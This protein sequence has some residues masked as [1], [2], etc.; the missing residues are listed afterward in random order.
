MLTLDNLNLA[1]GFRK[2]FAIR[3]AI[4]EAARDDVF[5]IRH[6]VYCNDL[7][8]EPTREDGRETDTH[9]GNSLHCLL[10]TSTVPARPVGCTRVVLAIQDEPDY[11]LPFE[12][13]CAKTLDRSII[14]PSRLARNRI[15]E[16]SRLAVRASYRRRRGEHA[17]HF[18]FG[19]DDYGTSEQ[20]RFP[21][22]P[23]SLYL[24][25]I[26]LAARNDIEILF[27]LTEPRLLTHF[28]RLGA[29]MRQIG[30]PVSHRGVRVPSMMDVQGVIKD[31]PRLI[32]P[33]WRVVQE[34]IDQGFDALSGAH[35]HIGR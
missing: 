20:P 1:L 25:S 27:L 9:D 17:R 33:L 14:D 28:V 19:S 16:V 12:R 6:E 5:R 23:I 24:G 10:T 13:T 3:P 18:G 11:L 35:S 32:K 4:T 26:A 8:F 30:Q 31:M 15:A 34:Q 21:Y 2:Y 29:N 7:G 22:V